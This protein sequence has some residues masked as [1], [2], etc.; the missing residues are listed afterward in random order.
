MGPVIQVT[1]VEGSIPGIQALSNTASSP[2]LA[3]AC[4]ET[5]ES[6]KTELLHSATQPP[7]EKR[8]MFTTLY[9]THSGNL[10]GQYQVLKGIALSKAS[11]NYS[12][13]RFY[14]ESR[15][16]MSNA[17]AAPGLWVPL[18]V[19]VLLAWG[20]LNDHPL[21]SWL[22]ER[23][24]YGLGFLFC[25]L[26][27]LGALYG[28][29]LSS[30]GRL[31]I[32]IEDEVT[33][34]A[35]DIEMTFGLFYFP[36]TILILVLFIFESDHLAWSVAALILLALSVICL[37]FIV[38]FQIIRVYQYNISGFHA[39]I[40]L[41]TRI[42]LALLTLIMVFASISSFMDKSASW[43]SRIFNG[44]FFALGAVGSY[45]LMRSLVYRGPSLRYFYYDA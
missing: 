22:E 45:L 13:D 25:S 18:V 8:I 37:V 14:Q 24:G 6:E 1:H 36:V 19:M 39:F 32:F 31:A 21:N 16:F 38:I 10:Q 4:R 30:R 20:A 28:L 40:A 34:G 44:L 2:S 41:L 7:P 33:T 29:F 43:G 5:S 35:A 23:W 26:F 9:S 15:Y 3:F 17:W 12:E 42:A 27:V 11:F